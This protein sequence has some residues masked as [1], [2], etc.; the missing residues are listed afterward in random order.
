MTTQILINS[1]NYDAT[2]NSFKYSFLQDQDLRGYE[3]GVS[4]VSVFNQFY[5]ISAELG[6]NKI[7]ID[8]PS[9]ASAYVFSEIT[10]DDGFYSVESFSL[11]LQSK[12]LSLKYTTAPTSDTTTYYIE[13]GTAISYAFFLKTYAVK[14]T[15]VPPAGA[16]WT[17]LTGTARSPRIYWGKLGPVYGFPSENAF[18]TAYGS[19]TSTSLVTN[20]PITPQIQSYTNLIFTCDILTNGGISFPSTFL[21]CMPIDA[22]F[23]ASIT[24]KSTEIIY[25]RVQDRQVKTLEIKILDQNLTPLTIRD[26]NVLIL[27]VLRKVPK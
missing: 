23:G 7:Q 18:T 2:S 4:N 15:D 10:I 5:N 11:F 20:S 13:M 16:T 27:L 8:F 22:S 1:K 26:S 6:N 24:S 12:C 19:T 3:L 14:T 25:A 21:Y 17:Q 9:G